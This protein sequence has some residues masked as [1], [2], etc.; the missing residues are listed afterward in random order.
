MKKLLFCCRIEW[1]AADEYFILS[2]MIWNTVLTDMM[3]QMLIF[4]DQMFPFYKVDII[5]EGWY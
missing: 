5:K 4:M 3:N 2:I 1:Y